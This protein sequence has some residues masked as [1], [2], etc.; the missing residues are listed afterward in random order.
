MWKLNAKCDV[1]RLAE[2]NIGL[3]YMVCEN[4]HNCNLEKEEVLSVALLGLTKAAASFDESKGYKFSTYAS[5]VIR[6]EILM[7][8]RK[9]KKH[10]TDYSLD[11]EV[12]GFKS[13]EMENLTLLDMISCKDNPFE[14]VENADLLPSLISC[15][16]EREKNCILLSIVE[17]KKQEEVSRIL[18]ISQSYVSR[19]MK[20]GITKIRKA[21]WRGDRRLV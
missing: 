8:L 15:L 11:A 17:E 3:A 2:E 20:S 19:C 5:S 14:S 21:Y 18:G 12:Q 10:Q 1:Q 13:N 9:T 16:S 4:F 6:N 7:E